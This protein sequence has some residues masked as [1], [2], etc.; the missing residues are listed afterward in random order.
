[1]CIVKAGYFPFDYIR[2]IFSRL[3]FPF[4]LSFIKITWAILDKKI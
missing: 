4:Y 1:M 2:R 3:R